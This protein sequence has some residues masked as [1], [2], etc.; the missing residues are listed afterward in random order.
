[1][2]FPRLLRVQNI[3]KVRAGGWIRDFQTTRLAGGGCPCLG[4]LS[5]RPG[6]SEEGTKHAL[7]AAEERRGTANVIM[8]RRWS[9][10]VPFSS[11]FNLAAHHLPLFTTP[12]IE[13][14]ILT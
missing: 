3:K 1:M 6:K 13:P 8:P 4:G 10:G 9:V 12:T 7:T 11:L 14:A 5:C 2:G